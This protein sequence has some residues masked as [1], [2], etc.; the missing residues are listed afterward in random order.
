MIVFVIYNSGGKN[1]MPR[2]FFLFIYKFCGSAKVK[3]E[4]PF[5]SPIVCFYFLFI[6]AVIKLKFIAQYCGCIFAIKYILP[7]I[8]LIT[9]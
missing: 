8:Q 5:I 1:V 6:F 7:S 2:L 3:P 4:L 9:Q